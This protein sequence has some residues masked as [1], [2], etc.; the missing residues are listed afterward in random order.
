MAQVQTARR[1]A[2]IVM[3]ANILLIY[4]RF[5]LDGIYWQSVWNLYVVCVGTQ[6]LSHSPK[7]LSV[8]L[9]RVYLVFRPTA[10][11][12]GLWIE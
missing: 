3:R 4:C 1:E 9:P 12:I 8:W 7:C 11:G 2:V 6:A 10:A 5:K